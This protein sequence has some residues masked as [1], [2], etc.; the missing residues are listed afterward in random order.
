MVK[1]VTRHEVRQL[2]D[3]GAQ[4]VEVLP[5][6]EFDDA[7]LPGAVSIPLDKLPQEAPSALDRQ[8]PVVV[9]CYDSL[10][11]MSARAARRLESLG[12]AEVYDYV[13]SKMDWIGA[14]LPFEGKRADGPHLATLADRSV[15]TCSP[16]EKVG[17]VRGRLDGWELCP[18]IDEHHVVL[19]LIRAEALAMEPGRQVDTVMQEA[20]R[21][22]RPHVTPEELKDKLDRSPVPWLLVTNLDGTLVGVARPD[23]VRS[24]LQEQGN[25]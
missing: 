7:H 19:G 3:Q 1:E 25:G 9:Y 17:D 14:G 16:D 4:L 23:D 13:A 21:T 15:P 22:H 8:G 6:K 20:P 2:V 18:V 10:C 5:S 11:D 12:F 24:A